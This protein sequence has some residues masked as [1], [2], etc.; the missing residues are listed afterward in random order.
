M[1]VLGVALY[2]VLLNVSILAKVILELYT[3]TQTA[4]EKDCYPESDMEKEQ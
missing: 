3:A 4:K 1:M 2:W